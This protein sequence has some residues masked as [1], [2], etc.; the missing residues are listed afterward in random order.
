MPFVSLQGAAANFLTNNV[1]DPN[2]MPEYKVCAVNN[3]PDRL[4]RRPVR[5]P[6]GSLFSTYSGSGGCAPRG[7]SL[8]RSQARC[9][10]LPAPSPRDELSR[11]IRRGFARHL[12]APNVVAAALEDSVSPVTHGDLAFRIGADGGWILPTGPHPRANRDPDGRPGRVCSL[13]SRRRRFSSSQGDG[14]GRS[15]QR[16]CE[17]SSDWPRGAQ[18]PDP[19]EL[20]NRNARGLITR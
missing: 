4:E 2:G 20:L 14:A 6:Y 5:D 12:R 8:L 18:P 19:D 13:P 11:P 7:Q 16:A 9:A 17:R 10:L 15:A 3:Q 1:Y